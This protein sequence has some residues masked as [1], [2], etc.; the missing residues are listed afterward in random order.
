[1]SPPRKMR[2]RGC[3]ERARIDLAFFLMGNAGK[4]EV[5]AGG[6]IEPPIQYRQFRRSS[7]IAMIRIIPF[8]FNAFCHS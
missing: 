3:T 6:G 5:V 8:V 2:K 7:E 4:L 1:M